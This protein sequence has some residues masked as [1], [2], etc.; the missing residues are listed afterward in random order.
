[1]IWQ[2]SRID[3]EAVAVSEH[4]S[5]SIR[6]SVNDT[7]LKGLS[8]ASPAMENRQQTLNDS[9]IPDGLDDIMRDEER[10]LTISM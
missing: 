8:L 9:I 4:M 6:S 3:K 7:D 5:F 10:S 1:M 2:L